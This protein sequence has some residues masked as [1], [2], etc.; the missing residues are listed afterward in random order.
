[1]S[2]TWIV[3]L[4]ILPTTLLTSCGAEPWERDPD[5]QA[6][7]AACKGSGKELDYACIERHAVETLNPDVCRLA[8]IAIDDMCLQAVYE[9]AGDP[10]ICERIY[11]R[12]VQPN[13]QAYYAARAA[14]SPSPRVRDTAS[15]TPASP[16]PSPAPLTST[17]APTHTPTPAVDL[18]LS[19]ATYALVK[20][21]APESDVLDFAGSVEDD[22]LARHAAERAQHFPDSTCSVA[23]D[24]GYCARLGDDLLAAWMDES[25][26]EAGY[27]IVARNDEQV[28][29]IPVGATGGAIPSLWGLWAYDGHWAVETAW[30]DVVQSGNVFTS[31]ATGQVV[32]DGVS[33]NDELGYDETFGF[34]TLGGKPFYFF[35]HQATV[36]ASYDGVDIPLGF[37][38]V[39]HLLCCSAAAFNPG[40][41][42]NVVT[43]YGRKGDTWYYGEIAL[44]PSV[45]PTS[46]A[47][48][49]EGLI[50]F[51]DPEGRLSLIEPD[52][53]SQRQLTSGGEAFAP[54]WSPDGETLAYIYQE[55]AEEPRR[56]ALYRLD[57][58]QTKLVGAREERLRSLAWSPDGR[59]L[60]LDS[61]TSMA[62]WIAI[63]EVASGQ[64]V[65]ESVTAVGFAWSPDGQRLA[66]GQL[67]PLED[68]ISVE[69]GDSASFAVLEVG[70]GASRVVLTGTS[71]V[72]YFP[73]AWLPDGRLLYD[74]LDW[75]E[76]AG[77]GEHSRWTVTVDG[78]VSTPE[79]AANVPPAF[80]REVT[81]ARL[82]KAFRDESTGSFSW[83][84]DGRWLV[85]HTRLDREMGVYVFDWEQGGEPV[86]LIDGTSPAWRPAEVSQR[87]AVPSEGMLDCVPAGT[88]SHCVDDVLGIEFEV[89]ASWGPIETSLRPGLDAGFAYDY[90]FD[91]K[92][93]AETEPLVA[94]G[95][96]VDFSEGRGAMP[97]DFG[98]YEHA[99]WQR[100]SA[101]AGSGDWFRNSYPVCQQVNENVAWMIRFPNASVL[102]EDVLGNWQTMPVFRIEINLPD[103]PTING[104]IFEAPF[105]SEQFAGR[106]QNALY[107]LL[108]ARLDWRASKCD[109]ASREAFDAQ[110]MALIETITNRTADAETLENV[111]ELVYLAESIRCQEWKRLP[112]SASPLS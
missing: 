92:A 22:P 61:G 16:T 108:G 54:A 104:F 43:F 112:F 36:D 66:L 14:P 5:V 91:G 30:V 56:A 105:F 64:T 75:D 4:L 62:G 69:S 89:P 97:T 65:H 58:G 90:Y 107:P 32:V 77:T 1:M 73:R 72:L 9:A 51:V 78:L 18:E 40:A 57:T 99:G 88:F 85:F 71:E 20:L 63:V 26:P 47:L 53:Q 28:A 103:K 94:G 100:T 39:L 106:L 109:E 93:H 46:P 12:G 21:P 45:S 101:C 82:P 7:K 60:L 59:Y 111:D 49:S 24:F 29:R 68:P 95:R 48:A 98:G 17:P 50:A 96:S 19:V 74:R 33:L 27:V 31:T 37:D 13:C 42:P 3:L 80:D 110:L 70:A 52:G 38:E 41:H 15:P 8:G 10:A 2:R 55:R 76:D 35:E 102:C 86:R 83:S 11:L 23:G 6:T 34:Q 87:P 79:P 67:Q 25:D 81:L 44:S 84:P